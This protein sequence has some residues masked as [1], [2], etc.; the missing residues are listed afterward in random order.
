MIVFRRVS[1]PGLAADRHVKASDIIRE[2]LAAYVASCRG[3]S[4]RHG[5]ATDSALLDGGSCQSCSRV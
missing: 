5:R 3:E 4:G 2:A 1:C